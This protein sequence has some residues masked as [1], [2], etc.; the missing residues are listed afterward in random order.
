MA[1]AYTE[2]RLD[3]HAVRGW[4]TSAV[5]VS[6]GFALSMVALQFLDVVLFGP[7]AAVLTDRGVF[8][9]FGALAA[10]FI[11]FL[12]AALLITAPTKPLIVAVMRALRAPRGWSDA[13]TGAAFGSAMTPLPV[14]FVNTFF[15]QPLRDR[16]VLDITAVLM[17]A[18]IGATGAYCHWRAAGQPTPPYGA[19][20]MPTPP[21]DDGPKKPFGEV[22]AVDDHGPFGVH[23]PDEPSEPGASGTD[24][25]PPPR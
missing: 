23:L 15:Y 6:A 11:F 9:F 17:G 14:Y 8:A 12:V 21:D 7:R 1:R 2:W 10:I 22:M 13:V 4:L 16:A 25:A 24:D 3:K 5:V 18:A 20:D 19:L